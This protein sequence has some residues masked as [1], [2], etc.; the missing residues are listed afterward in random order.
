MADLLLAAAWFLI[1]PPLPLLKPPSCQFCCPIQGLDEFRL[2]LELRLFGQAVCLNRDGGATKQTCTA[3]CLFAFSSL[4]PRFSI[5]WL[6]RAAP[7]AV[8][9]EQSTKR[10]EL[11]INTHIITCVLLPRF[12]FPCFSQNVYKGACVFR[13]MPA[14]AGMSD[15]CPVT[16][17][18][19]S[20]WRTRSGLC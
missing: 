10:L 14:C 15:C 8:R 6:S 12:M 4:F 3:S 7:S 11:I 20:P 9:F 5:F 2:N 13:F 17:W 18:M 1:L 16:A 19:L